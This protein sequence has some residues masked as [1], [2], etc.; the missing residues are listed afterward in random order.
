MTE[1]EY[2][3][4]TIDGLPAMLTDLD[5]WI[6]WKA[7]A[8]DGK[9]TKVPI[10]PQTGTY[11][12]TT[13]SETWASFDGAYGYAM[14][15]ECGLGFVF[16]EEDGLVGVDLDGCRDAQTGQPDPIAK[17]I[18]QKLDSYTEV[19]PSGTGYHVIVEGH[20]PEGRNRRDW[21][22]LYDSA[23][24]FTVTGLHVEGTPDIVES[25]SEELAQVYWEHVGEENSGG[26]EQVNQEPTPSLSDSALLERARSAKNGEKFD[27]LWRGSI[28]G[29]ASQSEADMA[30]C[31]LLAFWTGGDPSKIDS[32]FRDSG[33]MR[34]KWDEQHYADGSTYGD[35]TVERAV[36]ITDEFYEPGRQ[37]GQEH[38]GKRPEHGSK[39][40]GSHSGIKQEYEAERAQL[41]E[42][43]VREL[44][45]LLK[46]KQERIESLEQQIDRS[47]ATADMPTDTVEVEA[48]SAESDDGEG[49][50]RRL[51]R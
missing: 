21:I 41:L 27:R 30:L 3:L 34:E 5:Q 39:T 25:R 46:L 38:P 20:L 31:C 17:E 7:E 23:R 1:L 47:H 48:K 16:S 4:S 6:C 26:R 44:E 13:D 49:L 2:S 9:P 35:V 19:S 51:F 24:F 11:A 8:R 10:N 45:A 29:Y 22:E 50:L 18:V 28:A 43:R 32:L 36:D 37:S 40:S 14:E 15:A 42:Q 12:S 33:L